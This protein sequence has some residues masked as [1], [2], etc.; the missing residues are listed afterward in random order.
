MK[1]YVVD[2]LRFGDHEKLRKFLDQAYGEASMGEIY[3]IPIDP[4]LL[5]P[6]QREHTDCQPFFLAVEL[7]PEAMS[8]ELLVRTRSR[9]RCACIAYA[10]ERQRA[11]A[12][13]LIDGILE[14]LEISV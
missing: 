9:V 1:Q 5:T 8:T 14:R 3:W 6:L 10:T 13:D 2:Q 4:G 7:R 11:W 12:L